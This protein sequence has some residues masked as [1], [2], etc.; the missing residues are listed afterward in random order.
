MTVMHRLRTALVSRSTAGGNSGSALLSMPSTR[1][2]GHVDLLRFYRHIARICRCE[3]HN[4]PAPV[5]DVDIRFDTYQIRSVVT[6][7]SVGAHWTNYAPYRSCE[8]YRS[9][10]DFYGASKV[11]GSHQLIL[12]HRLPKRAV[13]FRN[14]RSRIRFGSAGRL[15]GVASKDPIY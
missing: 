8:L 6:L 13:L 15:M 3:R 10:P 12:V 1:Q 14:K 4:E 2:Y 9:A 7:A 5:E 11:Y